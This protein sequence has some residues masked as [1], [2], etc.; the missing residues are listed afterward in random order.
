MTR[1]S[2]HVSAR[3]RGYTAI[4]LLMA[5]TVLALGA[6]GIVAMQRVTL[7]SN[8]YAKNLAIATRVGEAWA[9]QLVADSSRWTPLSPIGNTMWLNQ[10]GACSGS[11]APGSWIEPA[12]SSE[13]L[14]GPAFDALGNPVDL[15]VSTPDSFTQFCVHLR[16]AWLHCEQPPTGAGTKGSGIVRAEIRVF[17]RREDDRTSS[18]AAFVTTGQPKLC[19]PEDVDGVTADIDNGGYNAIYMSTAIREVPQ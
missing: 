1:R 16:F 14:F 9:D 6:A 10:A 5:L 12:W 19:N 8:R 18:S 13:R 7:E 4:E 2:P 11:V 3:P 15:G 17:W